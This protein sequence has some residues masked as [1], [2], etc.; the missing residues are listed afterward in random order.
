MSA[1]HK[2]LQKSVYDRWVLCYTDMKT[3]KGTLNRGFM[4]QHDRGEITCTRNWEV[5]K[6]P[7]KINNLPVTYKNNYKAYCK[8]LHKLLKNTLLYHINPLT[9]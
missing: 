7:F 1:G 3:I 2:N 4:R 8:P 6:P 5:S 9:I